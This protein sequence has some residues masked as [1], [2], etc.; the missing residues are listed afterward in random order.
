MMDIRI[1][2]TPRAAAIISVLIFVRPDNI[3]K[4]DQNA[5]AIEIKS[6]P[7]NSNASIIVIIKIK[8]SFSILLYQSKFIV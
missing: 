7:T 1:A 4:A 2:G 3:E 5:F 8:N 6:P